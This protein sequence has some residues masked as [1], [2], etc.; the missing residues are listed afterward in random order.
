MRESSRKAAGILIFAVLV[1]AAAPLQAEQ[2]DSQPQQSLS[3]EGTLDLLEG[4]WHRLV[5]LATV[6]SGLSEDRSSDNDGPP[7]SP[8]SPNDPD[9]TDDPSAP[10]GGTTEQVPHG[11]PNG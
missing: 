6:S 10:G 7:P 2:P 9:P 11:D 5:S 3:L 8:T 4:V 1:F